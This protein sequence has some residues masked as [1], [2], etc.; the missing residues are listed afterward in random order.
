MYSGAP[1]RDWIS[2][3]IWSSDIE[4]PGCGAPGLAAS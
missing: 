4:Y 1:R 3:S 2:P